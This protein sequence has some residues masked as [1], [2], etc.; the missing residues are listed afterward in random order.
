MLGD[1][2]RVAPAVAATVLL[3]G[4]AT[5]AVETDA[6]DYSTT[7]YVYDV[8]LCNTADFVRNSA[9]GSIEV[10]KG[11]ALGFVYGAALGA[12]DKSGDAE[13]KLTLMLG[14]ALVGTV[15]GA[16]YGIYKAISE[17]DLTVD[18]CMAREGFTLA[19]AE[20]PPPI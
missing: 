17:V 5:P 20:A 3:W 12:S 10:V 7:S 16:G 1:W 9:R 18:E 15:G 2:R 13:A 14:G 8:S 6:P 19:G 4:C 11:M